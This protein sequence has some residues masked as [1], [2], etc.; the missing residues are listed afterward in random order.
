MS[1]SAAV[2]ITKLLE[3]SIRRVET[4]IN[5]A[6]KKI[7]QQVMFAKFKVQSGTLIASQCGEAL[8]EIVGN[9]TSVTQMTTDIATGSSEQAQ[10]IQEVAKSMTRLEGL[11]QKNATVAHRA[12]VSAQALKIQVQAVNQLLEN[13]NGPTDMSTENS[14]ASHEDSQLN[15][16]PGDDDNILA[17]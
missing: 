10:G 3:E 12:L 8:Q 13:F 6:K 5:D 17:A 16:D 7:D 9:V 4:I 2:E 15:R 1:G 14:N 11:N